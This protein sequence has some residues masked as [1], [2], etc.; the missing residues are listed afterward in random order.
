MLPVL[1]ITLTLAAIGMMVWF[2]FI[3]A[4]LALGHT[5]HRPTQQLGRRRPARWAAGRAHAAASPAPAGAGSD[6]RRAGFD[7]RRMSPRALSTPL[8]G[9][10]AYAALPWLTIPRRHTRSAS[11]A[12]A[13]HRRLPRGTQSPSPATDLLGDAAERPIAFAGFSRPRT[14]YAEHRVT[15]IVTACS[16]RMGMPA[17][18]FGSIGALADTSELQREAFN[19]AFDAHGLDW[20]WSRDEY[21]ALLAGQRRRGPDRRLRQ[22]ARRGRRRRRHPRQQ[23]RVLP[24]EPRRGRPRAARR[25]LDTSTRPTARA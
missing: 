24:A 22:L 7:R 16:T 15:E 23:V 12:L 5:H 25:R 14:G 2:V 17:V 1:V 9:H 13:S 10:P 18:L 6:A 21:R 4:V 19:E 8:R 3:V 11:S 20:N